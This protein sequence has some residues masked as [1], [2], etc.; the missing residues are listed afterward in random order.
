MRPPLKKGRL[1]PSLPP[2]L[3]H[4]PVVKLEPFVIVEY[5]PSFAFRFMTPLGDLWCE[6][7]KMHSKSSLLGVALIIRSKEGPRFVFHYPPHLASRECRERPRYGTELDP[8]TP[9]T[10]GDEGHS[11]DDHLE[12]DIFQIHNRFGRGKKSRHVNLW[13]GDEHYES[14]GVQIVPWEHLDAFRIQDLASILTPARAYHKKCFELTLDPLH[15]VTYPM[16]IRED[17]QWKKK[18]KAKKAKSRK[19]TTSGTDIESANGNAAVTSEDKEVENLKGGETVAEDSNHKPVEGGEGGSENGNDEGSMTMFN[20]VFILNPGRLEA[21]AEVANIFEH[22]AKDINKALRYAQSYSNYVWKQS[23]MILTMK[24]KAREKSV[25]T[26][27]IQF[28]PAY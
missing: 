24:D 8:T 23:D 28:S 3:L 1:C 4:E 6:A 12:D 9:D 19:H 5:D 26:S 20:L 17:G 15:F 25:F 21:P 2:F 10:S 7:T 16:H 11:N 13:D 22:V 18:K 27:K 14:D